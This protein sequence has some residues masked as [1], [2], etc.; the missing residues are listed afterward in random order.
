MRPA[1][2]LLTHIYIVILGLNVRAEDNAA[3]Y[4][5]AQSLIRRTEGKVFRDSVVPQWL[6]GNESFWYRVSVG[7]DASEFVRVDAKTGKI[8]R[9]DSL[10]ELGLPE[11][12][13][14][15]T[16]AQRSLKPKRSQRNGDKTIFRV[17]NSTTEQESSKPNSLEAKKPGQSPDGNWTV[18]FEN[19]NVE[20]VSADGEITYLTSNGTEQQPYRRPVRWATDSQHC[21]VLRVRDVER[22][23][24][25][26]VESSPH[27]QLQP[28]L[29]TYDYLKPGDDLPHV[30]PVLISVANK[31]LEVIPDDLFKNGFTERADLDIRWSPRSDEFYFNY[32]QRG[33]QLYRVLA[34]NATSSRVRSVVEERSETFIELRL[35]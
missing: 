24:V 16:S 33:H 27:N 18:R 8:Q 15:S 29:L 26:V 17:K 21:V 35:E 13:H 19:H 25:T 28:K 10:K 32:N 11:S 14:S 20:L 2:L 12:E 6:P 1:I 23:E 3:L 7:P 9:V 5:R 34:V 4:E 22:R 30:N 31:K